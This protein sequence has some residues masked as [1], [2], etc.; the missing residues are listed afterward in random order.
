VARLLERGLGGGPVV[1]VGEV[2]ASN[3]KFIT[4]RDPIADAGP[5]VG[6][7][8]GMLEL[9]GKCDSVVVVPCD[10]PL[11]HPT[12][13]RALARC[14]AAGDF[15][16]AAPSSNSGRLLPIPGAWSI[17]VVDSLSHAVDDNERS[18]AKFAA[19]LRAASLSLA[20]L[21]ADAEVQQSDPDLDSLRDIDT[22][23]DLAELQLSPP[24]VRIARG[25]KIETPVAW[26]LGELAS[27]SGGDPEG[28]CV[29]NG[30]P[31]EFD[32]SMPLARRDAVSM[33]PALQ[34]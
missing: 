23:T 1:V 9:R 2:A 4:A 17:R 10:V 25:P 34:V 3:S 28:P 8:A 7:L 27:L 19:G 29:V 5:L 30:L 11:L 16:V 6:M 13:V 32:R 21:T 20:G 15:D 22:P 26:T 18:P 14:L 24:R 33:P 12:V 31:V